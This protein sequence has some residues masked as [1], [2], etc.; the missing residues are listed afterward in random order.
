M[1]DAIAQELESRIGLAGKARPFVQMVAAAMTDPAR[2]GLGGFLQ[3]LRDLGGDW[4]NIVDTLLVDHPSANASR[5]LNS[6]QVEQAFGV[7]GGLLAGVISKLG[8]AREMA[9]RALGF[10]VPALLGRLV[11]QG[12]VPTEL[13]AEA[14]AF[15]GERGQWAYLP[16]AAAAAPPVARAAPVAAAAAS[17]GTNWLPWAVGALLLALLLGFCSMQKKPAEVAPPPAATVAAPSGEKPSAAAQ[18]TEEPA[19][20]GLM[21][22]TVNDLPLLKVYFDSG[23]TE[24]AAEFAARAQPVIDYLKAHADAKALISG[25]N[26][27]TGDAAK[28]AE[29]SKNRAKVVQAALVAAGVPEDRTELVKP[30]DATGTAATN[31]ASRRVEVTVRK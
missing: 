18:A 4:G 28:N 21:F 5:L 20:A 10:A 13:P 11:S 1:F 24:V 27:P 23:K 16:A 19:G 8:L 29:L 30:A 12:R 14:A 31:A 6:S 17:S 25:F 7:P 9:V 2:G 15:I 22:S 26:D 3:R